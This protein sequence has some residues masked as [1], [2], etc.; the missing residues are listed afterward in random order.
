MLHSKNGPFKRTLVDPRIICRFFCLAIR[1]RIGLAGIR[2]GSS[3]K[4]MERSFFQP[5]ARLR[6]GRLHLPMFLS[7][8]FG[9]HDNHLPFLQFLLTLVL[10]SVLI[11][12]FQN[13]TNNSLVPAFVIHAFVNLSGEVLPLVEKNTE[14]QG[15]YR[16]WVILNMLLLLT[17]A[18]IVFFY[19]PGKLVRQKTAT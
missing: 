14:K 11:T 2:T 17:V 3:A 8:G 1:R 15:D 4:K 7:R 9:Q 13:N 6:L 16:A 19:G 12:W 10:L 18:A 5:F